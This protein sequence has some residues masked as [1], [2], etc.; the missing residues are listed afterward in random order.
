MKRSNLGPTIGLAAYMT[1]VVS[2]AAWAQAVTQEEYVLIIASTDDEVG[3]GT[4]S[5]NEN[6]QVVVIDDDL[7][8][9]ACSVLMQDTREVFADGRA[10]EEFEDTT[11]SNLIFALCVP[12][13]DFGE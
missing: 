6:S 2:A 3:S 12:K 13:K 5:L 9:A 10:S 8:H 7:D 1:C 11:R 4:V